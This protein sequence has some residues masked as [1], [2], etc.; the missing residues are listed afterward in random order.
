MN[1]HIQLAQFLEELDQQR[2]ALLA[3]LPVNGY[4]TTQELFAACAM[5][6]G[7]ERGPME[8][9]GYKEYFWNIVTNLRH[10][11]SSHLAL[12]VFIK[13]NKCS[14]VELFLLLRL[15]TKMATDAC[16]WDHCMETYLDRG[17][18]IFAQ[19]ELDG[20][21]KEPKDSYQLGN[22][23]AYNKRSIYLNRHLV[24]VKQFLGVLPKAN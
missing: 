13:T 21:F 22:V 7:L 19:E 20:L 23:L 5:W 12:A 3:H 9:N 15:L 11:T 4:Q 17:K 18:Y 2:K 6:A 14:N 24:Y 16:G 10:E 1:I 8:T